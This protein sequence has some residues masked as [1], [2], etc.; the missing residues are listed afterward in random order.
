MLFVYFIITIFCVIIK[1]NTCSSI[2]QKTIIINT[3]NKNNNNKINSSNIE[4]VLDD[5]LE[6]IDDL[7]KL[8]SGNSEKPKQDNNIINSTK[9]NDLSSMSIKQLKELA[10]TYKLKT[11]GTKNELITALSKLISN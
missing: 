3:N 4:D 8:L 10:K 5:T 1:T 9:L 2:I 11:T 7:D 6:D